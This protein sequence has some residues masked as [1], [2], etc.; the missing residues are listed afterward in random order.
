M[1]RCRRCPKCAY[2]LLGMAA[3]LPT[4]ADELNADDA[5]LALENLPTFRQ[6]I[7]SNEHT[8]F[9]CIGEPDEARLMFHLLFRRGQYPTLEATLSHAC[10]APDRATLDRLLEVDATAHGIPAKYATRIL[11]VLQDGANTARERIAAELG[12]HA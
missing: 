12:G 4:A 10:G 9:E 2:V 11:G 3:F 5:I 1:A 6:M 8:P 7:G